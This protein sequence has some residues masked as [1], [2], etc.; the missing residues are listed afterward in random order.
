MKHTKGPWK[1]VKGKKDEMHSIAGSHDNIAHVYEWKDATLAAAAPEMLEALKKIDCLIT[2]DDE[3][4]SAA[5]ILRHLET[6]LM[7]I[8]KTIAK[9]EGRE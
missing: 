3:Q 6:S 2:V 9:A 7:I 1:A 5:D 4:D 8:K